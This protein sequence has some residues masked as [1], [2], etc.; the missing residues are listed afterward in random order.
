MYRRIALLHLQPNAPADEIAVFERELGDVTDRI[1]GLAHAHLGRHFPNT[2]GG[3]DYT[4]D[5]AFVDRED[6]PPWLDQLRLADH[7]AL[8]A[9]LIAR[10]DAVQFAATNM[11][12]AEPTITDF[13]KRTLFL[14]V[15]RSTP[16]AAAQVFDRV[17][18][19]MPRYIPAIRNWGGD[20]APPPLRSSCCHGS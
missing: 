15:E 19:G 5:L 1:P 20:S 18:T 3:G 7:T 11:H 6:C 17:L 2:V 14:E 12:V 8:F 9:K 16:P 10:A 13:V 4:W